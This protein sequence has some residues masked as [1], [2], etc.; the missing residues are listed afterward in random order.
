ML[1]ARV[2]FGPR[3]SNRNRRGDSWGRDRRL[4][5]Q[6][7][8]RPYRDGH[9][10]TWRLAPR[11]RRPCRREGLASGLLPR[12]RRARAPIRANPAGE[13]VCPPRN[14]RLIT[15]ARSI[16]LEED[17]RARRRDLGCV[18]TGLWMG[19]VLGLLVRPIGWLLLTVGAL[20]GGIVAPA[21]A[22]SRH[23]GSETFL[24]FANDR[25]PVSRPSTR[26]DTGRRPGSRHPGDGRP[27]ARPRP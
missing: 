17:D 10:R 20:A 23:E 6:D 18:A 26:R 8:R 5:G 11:P 25:T 4:R 16:V 27:S 1:V 15:M 13:L 2:R 24:S 9:A 12:A 19:A 21:S 7:W 3:M 14:I 22:E